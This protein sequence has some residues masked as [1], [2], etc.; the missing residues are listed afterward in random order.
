MGLCQY[1][2]QWGTATLQDLFGASS[3]GYGNESLILE[4]LKIKLAFQRSKD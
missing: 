2:L 1:L 3:L 4:L